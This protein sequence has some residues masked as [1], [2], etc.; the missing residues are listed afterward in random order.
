MPLIPAPRRQKQVDLCDFEACLVFRASYRA[1]IVTQ[2]NPDLTPNPK[3]IVK[4]KSVWLCLRG[5][6]C[7][8]WM[9]LGNQCTT[10]QGSHTRHHLQHPSFSLHFVFF[11]FLRQGFSVQPWLSWNSL[12]RPGWPRSQ[13]SICLCLP[14]ARIKG[15]NY[16]SSSQHTHSFST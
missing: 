15:L 7:Y 12:C 6:G 11:C 10:Q 1:A 16:P 3:Q 13:K 5:H 4:T 8:T 14:S 2:R 9:P